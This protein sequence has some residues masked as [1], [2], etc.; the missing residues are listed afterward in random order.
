[1]A[2]GLPS[3]GHGAGAPHPP[4][5]P[6][7]ALLFVPSLRFLAA[8]LFVLGALLPAQSNG[9]EVRGKIEISLQG[10]CYYCP[11]ITQ[12]VIH[13]SE[14]PIRSATIDLGPYV[15][16]DVLLTGTWSTTG[17][18]AVI[19]VSAIQIVSPVLN[20]GGNS[21]LG[22]TLRWTTA[23]APGDFAVQVMSL[24]ASFVPLGGSSV[25]LLSP[26]S[27]FVVGT[28]IIDT[29][30]SFRT[31]L[32]IPTNTGLSGLHIFGQALIAP[33][34]NAPFYFSNPETKRIQ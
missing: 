13:G 26:T 33:A 27:L 11:P 23:G 12:Y 14:T 20:I 9:V 24:G 5:K 19:D 21:R 2:S 28:G 10:G 8:F 6:M 16:L 4:V 29:N 25:L 34:N 1:M 3:E 17:T 15:G 32:L 7:N 30:G 31:D 22:N 18:V